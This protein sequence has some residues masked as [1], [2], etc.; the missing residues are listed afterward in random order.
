MFV[1]AGASGKTGKVAAETLLAQGTKVRVLVRDPGQADVWRRRGAEVASAA[2][3]DGPALARA[4][5]GATGFYVLLP[6]NL[7]AQD[8]HAHR[9]GMAET[10]ARAVQAARV[11]HVVFLSAAAAVLPDGNGPAKDLHF[12]ENALRDTGVTVTVI[13][14]SYFQENILSALAPA[15]H[16]GIYPSFFSS[17]EIAFPT[18]ATRDVGRLAGR[19]FLEPPARS[20]VIDLVGPMYSVRQLATKLG[21]ALGR[22]LRVVDI[23]AAAHV[24]VLTTQ[25]G[26]PRQVAEALAEMF[27]CLASG[28]VAPRGDRMVPATTTLDEI[29]PALLADQLQAKSVVTSARQPA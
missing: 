6:E 18:V 9:R 28:R 15:E 4:L 5:E 25:A 16:Q 13:R 26:L 21:T 8:F 27:A 20:E 22:E 23:P 2:F 17:T 7:S 24:E 11:P 1:V 14:A 29:L 3:E 10:I 19:C 12:A